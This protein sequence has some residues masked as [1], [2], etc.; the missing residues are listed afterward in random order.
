MATN[1]PFEYEHHPFQPAPIAA[2][3]AGTQR[4]HRWRHGD[5][6]RRRTARGP[7]HPYPGERR[8]SA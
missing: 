4:L 6:D 7:T 2:P 3:S 5:R 1:T 8:A